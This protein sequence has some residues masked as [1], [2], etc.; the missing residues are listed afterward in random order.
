VLRMVGC[1][2]VVW[3]LSSSSFPMRLKMLS[4]VC[5]SRAPALP[6]QNRRCFFGHKA[7]SCWRS[8]R[9]RV[10]QVFC[11]CFVLLKMARQL[12]AVCEVNWRDRAKLFK[13]K[14]SQSVNVK[15]Q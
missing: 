10:E 5:C 1:G 11:Q 12:L 14:W 8:K 13:Y 2:C 4:H 9:Q 15:L 7:V 3:F 6:R